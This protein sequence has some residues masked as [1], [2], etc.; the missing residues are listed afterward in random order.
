MHLLP[1]VKVWST[2]NDYQEA[3]TLCLNHNLAWVA[4]INA[5]LSIEIYL[6]SF[7]SKPVLIS[8]FG[9]IANQ[10]F[11]KTERGH[12]LYELYQKIEPELQALM[13]QESKILKNKYDLPVMIEK[14]KDVF[15]YARYH[16]EPESIQMVDST[17][18]YFAEHMKELV[19][20][21]AQLT[22]PKIVKA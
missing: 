16:H 1:D 2:G 15:F 7:L 13:V 19:L 12:D 8:V 11:S 20:R 10:G 17:I 9:G 6:K 3:A 18:I 5:A 21:V 22:H 14:Y 4:A